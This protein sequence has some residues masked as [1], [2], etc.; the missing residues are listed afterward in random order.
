M[1]RYCRI[2]QIAK[3]K[4]WNLPLPRRAVDVLP[5]CITSIRS[6]LM[7]FWCHEYMIRAQAVEYFGPH[8]T[9]SLGW[10]VL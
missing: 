4:W 3:R 10:V 5:H 1:K 7:F 2:I 8:K 6:R 9:C